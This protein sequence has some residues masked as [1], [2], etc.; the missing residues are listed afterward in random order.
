V[1]RESVE[2][3]RTYNVNRWQL[4]TKLKL[5]AALPFLFAGMKVAAPLAVVGQIVVELTGSTSGLGYLI[6]T[7]QYY[8]PQYATLFWA[9]MLIT[10]AL[11]FAFYRAVAVIER[12][13]SP[14]QHEFRTR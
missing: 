7:T 5:P 9:A 14:W 12:F 2:L 11:G 3:L 8:G 4:Y 1:P 6:L 13:A 10:L